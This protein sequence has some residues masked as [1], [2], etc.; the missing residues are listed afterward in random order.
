MALYGEAVPTRWWDPEV[1]DDID[2]VGWANALPYCRELGLVCLALEAHSAVS[3]MDCSTLTPNPN[4]AVNGGT[5]A[6]AADQVMG[7]ITRR[8]NVDGLPATGSLQF[9]FHLPAMA[10]ITFR[11]T[12]LGG[13]RTKFIEVV[14]EDHNRDRCA[15]SQG[16][17]IVGGSS[18]GPKTE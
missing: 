8:Q 10:P 13:R 2:W 6:A 12:T 17:M 4:G 7:A 3:I 18:R 1:G 9:Q 15:T 11:A 14:V 5:V 16:T